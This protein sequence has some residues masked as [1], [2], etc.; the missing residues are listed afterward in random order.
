MLRDVLG[1][2]S[3]LAFIDELYERY[4]EDPSSVDPA[5]QALFNGAPDTGLTDL[6]SETT[7]TMVGGYTPV[8]TGLRDGPAA[9][10][11]RDGAGQARGTERIA[12]PSVTL[13][14]T[15]AMHRAAAA[16]SNSGLSVWPLVNAYRVRGHMI[17]HLD[18]LDMLE[19]PRIVELEPETYG[20]SAA[21]YDKVYPAA[22]LH[23]VEQ[24][25]L[26]EILD[27]LRA[28]YC[29][30][31]GVQFMHISSPI[32]KAWLADRME[33]MHQHHQVDDRTKRDML[34]QLIA[35]ETL[36]N[37]FH[38]K[39]PGTKRFSLEGGEGLLPL[40][41]L[42]LT[43][44]ARLGAIEAV[45]GMA[46]RGRLDVLV[47]LMSRK[48]RDLFAEFEDVE[49]EATMGGGDVKYHL[50]YSSDRVD[51]NGRE[52]HLSLAFNPSHLEA[53]DPV[54]VGRVRAKQRRHHDWEH[55]KVIGVLVH[56]DAA[57]AGQGL[58]AETLNLTNLHGYRTGGT[59]HIIVNNQ[60]GFTASPKEARSTPYCTDIAKMIECPIFHVNGEDLDAMAHMIKIAMEYRAQFKSDVVID[61]LCY[62]LF[63]HNEMDEPAFTQPLM[64]ERIKQKQRIAEIYAAK[65]MEAEIVSRD[66][67]E[68][69]RQAEKDRLEAELEI[70]RATE[71]RPRI[72]AMRGIWS[73]YQGGP[74][75]S[76][77]D[78]DTGVELQRL[79]AIT[80][81]MTTLPEGAS[82]HPKVGRLLE[83][84]AAMGRGQRPVDWGMAELLAYGS[85]LW[86][87]YNVRLTGQDSC[88]GTFSHRHATVVD[89]ASGH[90]YMLLGHL[91]PDQG[92]F[93][94]YDS[95]LSEAGVLGFEFGFSLDF[96]D[97]LVI[98]EA[99]FGDFANGAQ[100]IFDQFIF[101]SEDKWNRLSG[102]TLFL[103]HG[104]EGQ[105]PEH[106]SARI[107][108]FLQAAA[109]DN[110]QVCQPTTAAQIFHLL[111]RQVIRPWRKP[112]IVLT[113][114][115]LLRLPAASSPLDAFTRGRFERVLADPDAPPPDQVERVFLCSGKIYFDLVRERKERKDERT[116]IIR[117]E[118][119]YPWRDDLV[120][121]AV[122]QYGNARDIVWVQD[123][124][125]NMG[126]LVFVMPRL[127]ALLGKVRKVSR[128]ES[129]SPATGSHRAHV[130]EHNLLMNQAFGG[131]SAE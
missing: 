48:P 5:W 94:I 12:P 105:G 72:E 4:Q 9:Q 66:D 16:A 46:H 45:I 122:A 34:R 3:N 18:P 62:R 2:G 121:A 78:V 30:S 119:L 39:Y 77:A 99:Q 107:E 25:T 36:E 20:F 104:F 86:Q 15:P 47:H 116:V 71:Q 131:D 32:K 81:S 70:A 31:I 91:H 130:L 13:H 113:P 57:F 64:Y 53:I 21:D 7:G 111:R 93:R 128:D 108:R 92:G 59:V 65:L 83:Q 79:R 112:L 58:V 55:S 118:Q 54:V 124:P 40:M 80:E 75:T 125:A 37:F 126:S 120:K 26:R 67:I 28:T 68:A 19:R 87:G 11:R 6:D 33:R 115:S 29:G 114:K 69:M 84:R 41:D 127:Q 103:P 110:I 56:G 51:R 74:E 98:W 27:V 82:I 95:P 14:Q 17:A 8:R 101:A 60:I 129:A 44:A 109:E 43:H 106:S 96:P 90:E 100:V 22:G 35:T 97:A 61:M 42:M 73:Q 123:E 52:M 24:A 23:G 50:G 49:P 63:G 76:I 10:R 117:L 89:T 38:V 102:L 88:R 85:L 1:L